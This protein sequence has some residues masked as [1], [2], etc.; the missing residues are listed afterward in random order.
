M[1]ITTLSSADISYPKH[2][3]A[4]RGKLE[5]RVYYKLTEITAAAA[6][7]T[8]IADEDL[9]NKPKLIGVLLRVNYN[10]RDFRL[11]HPPIRS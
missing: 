11:S 9:V 7:C 8:D 4:R 5:Y 2:S 3:S 10:L 6:F 1:S